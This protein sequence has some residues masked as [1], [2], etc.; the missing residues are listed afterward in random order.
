MF[1]PKPCHCGSKDVSVAKKN[2]NSSQHVRCNACGMQTGYYSTATHA[3]EAWNYR[4][5]EADL[6]VELKA[7]R[8]VIKELQD[9]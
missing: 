7:A 8:K 2:F 3:V 9:D 6:M 1:K 4:P 5:R